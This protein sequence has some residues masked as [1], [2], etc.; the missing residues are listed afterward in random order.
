MSISAAG[1]GTII[2]STL[3]IM[4]IGST[5]SCAR[6]SIYKLKLSRKRLLTWPQAKASGA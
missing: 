6:L 4:A 1:N 5:K 3:A 2:T